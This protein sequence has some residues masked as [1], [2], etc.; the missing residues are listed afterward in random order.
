MLNAG[1]QLCITITHLYP[2][3]F[4]QMKLGT[5]PRIPFLYGSELDFASEGYSQIEKAEKKMFLF[6]RLSHVTHSPSGN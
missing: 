6:S 2:L 3:C 1:C 4:V 5:F